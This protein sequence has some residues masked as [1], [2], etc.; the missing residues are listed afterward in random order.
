[1]VTVGLEVPEDDIYPDR[2]WSTVVQ[3]RW[4]NDGTG[5]SVTPTLRL[6]DTPSLKH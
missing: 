3:V 4:T 6:F 2:E 1:M 5:T